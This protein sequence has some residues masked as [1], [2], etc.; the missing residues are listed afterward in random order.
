MELEGEVAW[1]LQVEPINAV[2]LKHKHHSI[3]EQARLF[4]VATVMGCI[5]GRQLLRI[6]GRPDLV[7]YITYG[8]QGTAASILFPGTPVNLSR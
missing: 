7:V 4:Q 6:Q 3:L 8:L 1:M 5:H 2:C